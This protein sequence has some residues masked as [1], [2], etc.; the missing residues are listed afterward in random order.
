MRRFFIQTGQD[1]NQHTALNQE[2]SKHITKV[3]RLQPGTP[4]ELYDGTGFLYQSII[5]ETGKIV[6]IQIQSKVYFDPPQPAV[7]LH[8]GLLKN[9]KMELV[10][11]KATE[12]GVAAV[13]LFTSDHTS[14][15]SPDSKK[16]K[17]YQ[18][19]IT[20][21]CKQCERLHPMAIHP[22]TPLD[23]Q[24][25][26][27]KDCPQRFLFWERE[28]S[29]DPSVLA[30]L[31]KTQEIH[32]FTGPEGGFSQNEIEQLPPAIT[33]VSLGPQILRAETAV[34][35]GVSIVSFL[36]GHCKPQL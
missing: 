23:D 34:I 11:Q 25:T 8:A 20:E 18:K 29:N 16:L 10:L 27:T 26:A 17:R 32:L 9:K 31:D 24:L 21:S 4:I 1:V 5:T 33:T 28:T 7:I 30:K 6:R 3:L 36:A 14:V 13:H 19:I 22:P 35:A 12:L 15:H 2:E